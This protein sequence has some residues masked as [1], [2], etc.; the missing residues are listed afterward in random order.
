MGDPFVLIEFV[1]SALVKGPPKVSSTHYPS[2]SYVVPSSKDYLLLG[3]PSISSAVF[4][5]KDY[6]P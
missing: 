6:F 3:L 2:F 4:S 5:E 1:S